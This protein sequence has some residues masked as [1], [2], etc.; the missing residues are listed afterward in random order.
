MQVPAIKTLI[1]KNIKKDEYAKYLDLI[2]NFKSEKAQKYTTIILSLSASIILGIFA[3]SPTLSTIANLQR[4]LDDDKFVEQKLQEKINN[5]SILQQKYSALQKDLP[6]IFAAV[7]KGSEIPSFLAQ[8]QGLSKESNINLDSFQ[9][10]K[11]QV[12][13]ESSL[14]KKYST[15]DFGFKVQGDYQTLI[16][17]L[18]KLSSFQRIVTISLVSITKSTENNNPS[19][20]L[21]VKG[22]AYFKK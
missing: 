19:L 4:Q 10:F 17:F 21:N 12:S 1:A 7:P 6:I 8:M 13:E 14:N 22:T 11:V 3:I 2:P 15:F 20:E 18:N 5:L 9:T 16:T